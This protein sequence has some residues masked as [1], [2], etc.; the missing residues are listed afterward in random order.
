MNHF[1][2]RYCQLHQRDVRGFTSRLMNSLLTHSFPGSIRELQNLIERGV[3]SCDEGE[4][5][6][7]RHITLNGELLED[8]PALGLN[9][10]GRLDSSPTPPPVHVS[11]E[12]PGP[13]PPPAA[14]LWAF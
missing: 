9:A 2:Q 5:M 14:R 6:D 3:I 1:L 13:L 7:L 8:D 4:P 10:D 12:A 11:D